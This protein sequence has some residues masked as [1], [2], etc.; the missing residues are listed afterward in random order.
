MTTRY[1]DV[2]GDT[3]D[4]RQLFIAIVVGIILS[5]GA[6][7][8]GKLLLTKCY[9]GLAT[10]LMLGYAL[11]SGMVGALASAAVCAAFF[12]PKRVLVEGELS[13]EDRENVI[14][15][16]NLDMEEESRQLANLPPDVITEMKDLQIY[17]L[18]ANKKNTEG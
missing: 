6:F 16:L 11:F 14:N 18:F 9:P 5:L 12:A 3:V 17:S 10:N 1:A 13:E 2:W 7:L 4:I 8:L 15:E